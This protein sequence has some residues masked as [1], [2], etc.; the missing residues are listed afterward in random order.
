MPPTRQVAPMSDKQFTLLRDLVYQVSGINFAPNKKYLLE[1]RLQGRLEARQ[2]KGFD[3]Y[4]YFLKFDPRKQEE[5]TF[6]FNEITT[7]ET[8]FFRHVQQLKAFEQ[9]VLPQLLDA[10]DVQGAR[11]LRIWSAACSSGEEPYSLAM[12]VRDVLGSLSGQWNVEILANDIS[13]QMLE[14]AE[15]GVYSDYTLRTTPLAMKQKHFDKLE[16]G[17]YRVKDDV[18]RMVRFLFLNFNDDA[19]MKTMSGMDIVFCR[20]VLI[21]FD[22]DA[23][24]RFVQHFYENLN[25]GGY[26]FIGHSESLHNVSRVF[27]LVHFPQAFAYLKEPAHKHAGADSG[28]G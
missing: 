21:Y 19:R 3:E 2:L 20:N 27:S 12:I 23:K 10:K 7:N 25:H 17:S 8:S 5:F 9:H 11:K 14:K 15:S 24:K 28:P 26:L 18:R 16:D 22:A 1:S 6:L 4:Y 13:S